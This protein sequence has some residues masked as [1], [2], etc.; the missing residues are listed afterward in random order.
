MTERPYSEID[1]K[2]PGKTSSF[3]LGSDFTSVGSLFH[4]HAA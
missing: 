3:A 2:M 4:L 1:F